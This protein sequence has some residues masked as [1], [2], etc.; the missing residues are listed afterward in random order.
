MIIVV[1][2]NPENALRNLK[3][4]VQIEHI[5]F[6][7]KTREAGYVKPSRAKKEKAKRAVARRIRSRSKR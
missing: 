1:G 3:K 7:V 6:A 5:G 4:G 2:F